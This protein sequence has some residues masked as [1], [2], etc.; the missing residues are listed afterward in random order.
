MSYAEGNPLYVE[1]II[2]SLIDGG[3]LVHDEVT[4]RWEAAGDLADISI[5]DTLHGVLMARIDRLPGE[6]RQVLQL[7]SVIGRIFAYRV[8]AAIAPSPRRRPTPTGASRRGNAVDSPLPPT[9]R[10]RSAKEGGFLDDPL[11]TLQ[12]A[13]MIRERARVPELEYIFKHH[14]TQEAAY[15]GLLRR[16][17]RAIHRRVAEALERLYPERLEEQVEL[18]AHHWEQAEVPEKAVGYLVQAGQSAAQRYANREALSYFEAAL[19]HVQPGEDTDRILGYRAKVYLNLFRGHEAADDY[20]RLLESA[21]RS[22]N[23]EAEIEAFLGLGRAHYIIAFDE[24]GYASSSLQ[25][26]RQAY[27][28]ACELGDKANMVRALVPTPW[29][30]DFWPDDIDQ[31]AVKVREAMALSE[32]LG[33]KELII[34][35]TMAGHR[36][37]PVDWRE[38]G[39]RLAQQLA[40][41]RDLPRL[42]MAYFELMWAHLAWGDFERCIECCDAGIRLAAE[43]GVPPVQYP[44]IKALAL[45]F[46]GRY[47]AA[48]EALALEVA[49]KEHQLGIAF[50][51]FGTGTCL[52]EWMACGEAAENFVEVIERASHIERAWLRDWA[53]IQLVKSLVRTGTIDRARLD[54]IGRHLGTIGAGTE[55]A[56]FLYKPSTALA[57]ISLSMGNLD[58]SLQH[59]ETACAWAEAHGHRVAYVDALEAQ[60]RIL[61]RLGRTEELIPLADTAIQVAAE[62]GYRTRV[63]HIR[64]SKARALERLGDGEAATDEYQAA[65]TLILQ[66]ATAIPGVE[67]KRSYLSSTIVSSILAAS[68]EGTA[69]KE[70]SK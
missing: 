13:Q 60:L 57:E 18:L 37:G 31:A 20:G 7:A 62:M 28:L 56:Y 25:F 42:N 41:R 53:R 47:K 65:A 43:I 70:N 45:S 27:A 9:D 24:R 16:D 6:A 14:L 44:T 69:G 34:E 21:T 40:S 64:A 29:F 30:L 32:E 22:G 52:L 17:R 46:L 12:R 38:K 35:S 39:E 1:E 19:Q 10:P 66:L 48:W 33:D 55:E 51:G 50:K 54:R 8:L 63:W 23:Q 2:R 26:Y 15:N 68:R 58:V 67:Y 5:P 11:L 36:L 49:D 59:I 3:T 61:L 4:D